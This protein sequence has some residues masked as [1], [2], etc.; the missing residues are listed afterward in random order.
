VT[1]EDSTADGLDES[2]EADQYQALVEHAIDVV[3][4][5]DLDSLIS[6]ATPSVTHVLGWDAHALLGTSLLDLVHPDDLER[7]MAERATIRAAGTTLKAAVP[8]QVRFRAH[9]G[10]YVAMSG[11]ASVMTNPATDS[12]RVI[13]SMRNVDGQVAAHDALR[14]SEVRYRL[15][16]ENAS[17]IVT[18]VAPD[19]LLVWMSPSVNRIL[20]WD[21]AE[22]IGS[23]PWNLIHPE[24][25]EAAAQSFAE[26]SV[27]DRPPPP[28]ELRFRSKDGNYV[29]LS[30]AAHRTDGGDFLVSYRRV[31]DQVRA[32]RALSESEE[33]FRLLAENAQD[34]V[35]SLDTHAI[36]QWVSPSSVG[37]L[38]YSPQ[39]LVGQFG[40]I[41][42]KPEDL[43]ILLD[44]ATEARE[45]QPA[46]CRI[47]LLTKAGADRWVQATPR[48]LYD[49]EGIL[50]G[51]VIGVRDV[52]DEV[53][54]RAALEHEVQFDGL[55][56]LAKRPLA[57]TRIQDILDTRQASGW[58]LL[59][60][61]VD[62]MTAINQAY[63]HVAGD[64]V[65]RAVAGRLVDAVGAAD[66]VARIAGD[67]FAVLMRDIV[68]SSDAANA[69]ERILSLVRG[70]VRVADGHVDVT[71]CLGIAFSDGQ[72]A[73]GLLRDATAAMR[74]AVA[75]GPNRWEF[76]DG[77]VGERS[78]E[79]LRIQ[80]ALVEDIDR[81]RLVPWLMPI[82]DLHD[83]RVVGYEAL[84]RWLQDDGTVLEP[85]TFLRIA[86]S[87]GAILAIDRA[88]LAQVVDLLV[89]LPVD[90]HAAVNMSAATLASGG[91]ASLVTD[92]LARAG[93]APRRLHLEVTETA[94]LRLTDSVRHNMEQLASLGISWWVDDFGTGFSSI[95]HLR[96]LPI[97]GLKL[98]QSFTR[99]LTLADTHA[100]RL[101]QGLVGL[102]EGLGLATIAEGI[103][104]REQSQVL[105]G[106]GWQRGQGMLYGLAAPLATASSG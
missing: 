24:D 106:Q 74:Q 84:V 94:L 19:G 105:I 60:V 18:L 79:T 7:A 16:A 33:R 55:T 20:G 47:R 102:A 30:A 53:L 27:P 22:L 28:V 50:I 23:R 71:A 104:T 88:M 12:S 15:L 31:E 58:A 81:G 65:L 25:R 45:G 54:T 91:L 92:E 8:F 4:E 96:D 36:I 93:A 51:G 39:E 32:R 63:T 68:S 29:W 52:H 11:T 38:D 90:Q 97:A 44:T 95:S 37:L 72:T 57:L 85:D 80:G 76:L 46:T 35:F 62:G 5:T 86:E 10:S 6:W 1:T 99:T 9:D 13:T 70:P 67:E 61:G 75:I 43:P 41:L 14:S 56:G 77:N 59:C 17:D 101:A 98:D 64:D 42:I 2:V 78:R 82:V 26:A 66:R 49:H 100:T 48:A 40:G 21:P 103:E 89:T 87:T 34:L 83:G 3:W 73:D 69:A